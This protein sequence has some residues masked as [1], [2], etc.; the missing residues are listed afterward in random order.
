MPEADSK[1]ELFDLEKAYRYVPYSEQE[2]FY[3]GT[4]DGSSGGGSKGGW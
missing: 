2:D 1:L 4:D 3:L